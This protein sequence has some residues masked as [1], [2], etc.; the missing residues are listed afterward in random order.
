MEKRRYFRIDD[1]IDMSFRVL[2]PQTPELRLSTD[3]MDDAEMLEMV[4]GELDTIINSLWES[5]PKY[6]KAIGL[7]NQ[8]LNLLTNQNRPNVE[9]L[10]AKYDHQFR[11][12]DV[13][14]SASGMAFSCD[15][16]LNTGDRLE[17]L[18]FLKPAVAAMKLKCSVVNSEQGSIAGGKPSYFTCIEFEVE[19]KE[20]E[21]LIQHIARRQVE[22]IGAQE[23]AV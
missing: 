4:D 23:R 13:N 16:E 19:A 17:M 3:I 1:T 14:I 20:K 6:A 7:L 10:M 15:V 18:M 5:D 11:D 2:T 21:Q 9:E 8:K 22:L 12:I